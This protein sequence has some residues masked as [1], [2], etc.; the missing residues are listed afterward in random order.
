MRLI[1]AKNFLETAKPGTLY[2]R[3]WLNKTEE[4]LDLIERYNTN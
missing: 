2:R 3:F 1:G 4:C